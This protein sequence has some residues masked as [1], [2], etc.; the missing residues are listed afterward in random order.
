MK[1]SF[2]GIYEG[3][4]VL[5]T[6]H[7]GFKGSWLSLWLQE[8]GANVIGLSLEPST[9]PSNFV[10]SQ[11]SEGIVHEIGDIRDFDTVHNLIQKH[12]PSIVFHLAAQP[13]VL[14]SYQS[15]KENF[16]VNVGG[17]VNVLEAIRLCPDVR[18][19]VMV[20]SDKCYENKEWLWGYREND[21]LG[22]ADPYSASKCMAEHAIRS[23]RDSFFSKDGSAAIASARAGNVIGGG[24]FSP[25]RIV[26]DTMKA[27]MEKQVIAVRNPGS[28]RP[29]LHV[30]DPLNGY[31]TL[32]SKLLSDGK[33]FASAWNFGPLENHGIDVQ[34]I[35][36][37]AIECWGDG[38]WVHNGEKNQKPE[39]GLLRLNWDKA[40]HELGW[41]AQ[42]SWERAIEQTVA[43]FSAFQKSPEN[44]RDVSLEQIRSFTMESEI[45]ALY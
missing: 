21:P 12:R 20:T 34:M 25:H 9:V 15:P 10:T 6:G 16:D 31:L 28:V 14:T 5:L 39:M 11:V 8:L 30:L 29:W 17:T 1:K 41:S 7:T 18:A 40:A 33:A 13:I 4:T 23:Y 26:P 35:V 43:W 27:L 36:E 37:K 32:G 2:G 38:D 24:D 19:A 44:T 3:R 22:G 42:Y 45:H